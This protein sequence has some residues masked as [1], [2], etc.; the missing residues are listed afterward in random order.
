MQLELSLFLKSVHSLLAHL[1]YKRGVGNS[2]GNAF[3]AVKF[4]RKINTE[5]LHAYSFSYIGDRMTP[6]AWH[7]FNIWKTFC[8]ETYNVLAFLI[9]SAKSVEVPIE[10]SEDCYCNLNVPILGAWTDFS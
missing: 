9:D 2:S 1:N 10:L 5:G 4:E 6:F 3:C 7:V 8:Q